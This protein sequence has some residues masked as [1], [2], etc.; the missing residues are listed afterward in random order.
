MYPI[1]WLCPP[2]SRENLGLREPC[3]KNSGG[4]IGVTLSA[5]LSFQN[6]SV[7]VDGRNRDWTTSS[8]LISLTLGGFWVLKWQGSN[9]SLLPSSCHSELSLSSLPASSCLSLNPSFPSSL[10][11]LPIFCLLSHPLLLHSR[12]PQLRSHDQQP[13]SLSFPHTILN[14]F[15]ASFEHRPSGLCVLAEFALPIWNRYL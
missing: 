12:V 2:H 11:F 13:Y 15:Q 8:I 9:N 14:K 1:S 6:L 7:P 4:H 3:V 5:L 10:I